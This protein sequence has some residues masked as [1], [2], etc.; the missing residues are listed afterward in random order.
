MLALLIVHFVAYA[1]APILVRVFGRR[2]F[3]VLTIP[4]IGTAV[5]ATS[6]APAVFRGDLPDQFVE[7]I[8]AIAMSIDLR[9][10]VLS[11]V[12]TLIISIIGVLVLSYCAGYFD[13]GEPDLG[14]FAAHLTAFSGAMLGLVWSDNLLLL[15]LFW[16]ITTVLSYLLVGHLSHKSESRTA[17][18][19]ALVVT[20]FGGLAM[21]VG[22]VLLGFAAGSYRVSDILA[23]PP[24]PGPVVA[25]AVVLILVGAISKSALAPFHFWLPGAMA[26]PTPVSAYL[27]AAAMVKAGIYLVARFAAGFADRPE[28]QLTCLV[29]GG[30]TMVIGGYR[31]LRQHDLKLLLAYGTVSQLGFLVI[32]FGSGTQNAAL[33]GLTML[34]SHAVFKASLFLTVGAIDH[35]TGT[36]DLRVLHGLARKMP[37]LAVASTLAA[38]SMAGVPPLLGFVGKEAAYGAL[39]HGEGPF[40]TWMLAVVVTGSVLTFAYSARFVWGAWGPGSEAEG[41]T[42]THANPWVVTAVPATLGFLSLALAFPS[43]LAE[44]MFGLYTEH[45]PAEAYAAHLGLW[46]GLN[47]VLLLSLATLALGAILF[48]LRVHIEG[49][50]K[51]AP[52]V[53]AAVSVY[54]GVMKALDRVSLEVTGL[55]HRGSLPLSLSLILIVLIVI[56]G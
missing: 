36:R 40:S 47:V 13:E 15:Y 11:W 31:A 9:M 8:P 23:A 29:L 20:T 3:W 32:L 10:D 6:Q 46:H 17:A 43:A 55:M 53:P 24:E 48:A 28:W 35:A 22:M 16:E 51:A 1:V 54:R 50:Q 12:L 33:A 4:N 41:P 21:L 34:V 5:W 38:A 44:P 14:R 39:L 30:L 7:W 56:P 18:T 25:A 37:V 2:A 27:H 42:E 49:W 19:Q 52:H 45:F 26:A